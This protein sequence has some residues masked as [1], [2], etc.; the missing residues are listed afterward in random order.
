MAGSVFGDKDL[1]HELTFDRC[2][3]VTVCPSGQF[4]EIGFGEC[5]PEIVMSAN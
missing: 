2:V 4:W 1:F 3:C 5:I